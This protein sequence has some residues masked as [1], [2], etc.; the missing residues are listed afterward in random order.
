MQFSF[1]GSSDSAGIPVHNCNCIAC[2]TYR[3]EKK[4]NHSTCAYI[5]INDEIILLDA[6]VYDLTSR[7]DDKKINAIFLT[8][9]HPDHCVG[10]LKLRYSNDNINCFHPEDEKGFSDL[11]KHKHSINYIEIKPFEQKIINEIK[12]TTIPLK[13]SKNTFGYLIEYKNYKIAYLT[14]CSGIPKES[15]DFLQNFEIDYAFID[16]CYDERK[17]VGNHLNYLQASEILDKL[18]VK[19]GFLM[20]ISHITQEYILKNKIKLKYPYFKQDFNLLF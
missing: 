9:F 1:L 15:F 11:F 12:F 4:E 20:H 7:F 13:H 2:D 16:A 19:N 8:H 18:N 6:G 10:L 17:V 14:D 5:K 3:K